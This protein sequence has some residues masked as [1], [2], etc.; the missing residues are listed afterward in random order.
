MIHVKHVIIFVIQLV[1]H[2]FIQLVS[3]SNMRDKRNGSFPPSFHSQYA[4]LEPMVV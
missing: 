4:T 2:S 1:T 3:M